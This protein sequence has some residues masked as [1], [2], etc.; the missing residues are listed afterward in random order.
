MRFERQNQA[1]HPVRFVAFAL[2]VWGGLAHGGWQYIN[3]P[4][5][6]YGADYVASHGGELYAAS[7]G[8]IFKTSNDGV[9]WTD[10]TDGFGVD[11]GN[12]NRFLAFSGSNIFVGCTVLGA[13]MS[14]D[15]GGTWE[16]DTTGFE[17]S[18]QV[19]MMHLDGNQLYASMFWP[20]Y[21]LY[22]KPAEP[23][24]WSRVESGDIG[25][26]FNTEVTGM[27]RVGGS[28]FAATRTSGVYES[29][30]DGT[31]W[32]VKANVGYP[33]VDG[34]SSN[35]LVTDGSAIYLASTNG[36]H[37]STDEGD[38]WTRVDEG[39]ANWG[40]FGTPIMCLRAE[41]GA[42]FAS[43]AQDDSAYVSEDSGA[44]WRD[45]SDGLNHWIQS[46]TLHAGDLYAAQWDIDSALVKYDT[47]LDV[48]DR[49]SQPRYRAFQLETNQPNPFNPVTT[50]RYTLPASALP[51]AEK[52]R[53]DVY[54][55]AGR[56][57]ATLVDEIQP[58]GEHAVVFQAEGLPSGVYVYSLMVGEY[59][60]ERKML[61]VK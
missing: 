49:E 31:S 37:E 29:A 46:F 20:T 8:G 60:E 10:L 27:C 50:I 3:P 15:G 22:S 11:G 58:A 54:D 12:S 53:L 38:N 17:G 26:D 21:G 47:P 32:S 55:L 19:D 18:Y 23:G 43:M 52:V 36:V 2:L 1:H 30:D 25:T 39:F 51:A 6:F 33:T 42:L 44:N 13:F 41:E 57:V 16:M 59:R 61:L 5:Q 56:Q 7:N 9:D 45:I 4:T 24:A 35:R 14:P 48:A 40:Q 34:Y 28:V